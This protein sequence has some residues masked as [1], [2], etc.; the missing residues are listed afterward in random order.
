ME[1]WV[2]TLAFR[3]CSGACLSRH[4][5]GTALPD[6]PFAP[7]EH[8]RSAQ[9]RGNRLLRMPACGAGRGSSATELLGTV[10]NAGKRARSAERDP[11]PGSGLYGTGW[12]GSHQGG[13]I[14]AARLLGSFYFGC[15][16]VRRA[17]RRHVLVHCSN[18]GI[19]QRGSWRPVGN[20][21]GTYSGRQQRHAARCASAR[22]RLGFAW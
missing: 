2:F 3:E 17:V 18:G 1:R 14:R 20:H 22:L 12:L 5:A 9:L 21:H 4:E 15:G 10:G 13:R 6:R 19:V 8:A 16:L 11:E 7:R